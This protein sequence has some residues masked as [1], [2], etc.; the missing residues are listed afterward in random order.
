MGKLRGMS[1]LGDHD[2]ARREDLLRRVVFFDDQTGKAA[3][4]PSSPQFETIA[5]S[6]RIGHPRFDHEPAPRSQVRGCVGEARDLVV[7]SGHGVEGVD[8]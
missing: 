2:L 8:E 1:R 3:P 7:L 4:Q 5:T 6:R